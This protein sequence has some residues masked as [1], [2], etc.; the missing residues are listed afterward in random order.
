MEKSN[1]FVDV[2]PEDLEFVCSNEK[3]GFCLFK[4][5]KTKFLYSVSKGKNFLGVDGQILLQKL[6]ILIPN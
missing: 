2:T 4:D 5:K 1:E 6:E 3:E